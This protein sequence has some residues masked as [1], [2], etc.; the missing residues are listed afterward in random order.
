MKR[1]LALLG[2]FP[3]VW[4]KDHDGDI[5]LRVAQRS[6]FGSWCCG[7]VFERDRSVTLLCGG[8]TTGKSYVERWIE[9][10]YNRKHVVFEENNQ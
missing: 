7:A 3:L 8:G 10:K 1:I 6:Q 2:F 5:R 9:W 4:T